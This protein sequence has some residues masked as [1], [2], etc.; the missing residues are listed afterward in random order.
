MHKQTTTLLPKPAQSALP[1]RIPHRGIDQPSHHLV[2]G[3]QVHNEGSHFTEQR[4][5]KSIS[6]SKRRQNFQ[7]KNSNVTSLHQ[8]QRVWKLY[9][10]QKRLSSTGKLELA[11]QHSTQEGNEPD[12]DTCSISTISR[13]ETLVSPDVTG[14]SEYRINQSELSDTLVSQSATSE[15]SGSDQS[16]TQSTS[17]LGYSTPDQSKSDVAHQ[18]LRLSEMLPPNKPP[19]YGNSYEDMFYD[20]FV[21]LERKFTNTMKHGIETYLYPMQKLLSQSEHEVIFQ[22]IDELK[23]LSQ[24]YLIRMKSFKA[25]QMM[26]WSLC[27][28]KQ[29]GH[30]LPSSVWMLGD[31]YL[32]LT[33]Q[34]CE[35][36]LTYF[37]GLTAAE[38]LL[39]RLMTTGNGVTNFLSTIQKEADSQG[40]VQ[41][42][43]LI[44][45]LQ[46]PQEHFFDLV[47]NFEFLVDKLESGCYDY[48]SPASCHGYRRIL[49]VQQGEYDIYRFMH[50]QYM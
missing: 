12:L 14:L 25:S 44:D 32:S 28:R 2:V 18:P 16:N 33:T 31:V 38:L 29:E 43:S 27:S 34:L 6:H 17:G 9:R 10:Q 39:S 19:K 47:C 45:F 22:N 41:T 5:D 20:N 46:A 36:Y 4:D 50:I 13:C 42:L 1:E 30:S 48:T 7:N 37:Q 3:A 21:A 15:E 23:T 8:S 26:T 11:S 24:F 40:Q 35:A 49:Y